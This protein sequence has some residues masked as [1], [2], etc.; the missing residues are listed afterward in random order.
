[1][2]APTTMF[3]MLAPSAQ[4]PIA[5][6]RPSSLALPGCGS[7]AALFFV[8]CH[9]AERRR[10]GY[11][12]EAFIHRLTLVPGHL[13]VLPQ[14]RKCVNHVVGINCK[15]SVDQLNFLLYISFLASP[16]DYRECSGHDRA[17]RAR[18][19]ASS[20]DVR[21]HEGSRGQPG[22]SPQVARRTSG[23]PMCLPFSSAQSACGAWSSPS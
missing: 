10:A 11:E 1:M 17:A 4:V 7:G 18:A 20:L 13:E 3:T 14:M 5:R 8:T 19:A 23:L 21:N 2:P 15:L 22:R 6:T 9:L 16:A 12:T